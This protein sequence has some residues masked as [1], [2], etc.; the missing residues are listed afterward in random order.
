MRIPSPTS[1]LSSVS[2]TIVETIR[3]RVYVE[4]II[5]EDRERSADIEAQ[6]GGIVLA[7][8]T[9]S[10]LRDVEA[11]GSTATEACVERVPSDV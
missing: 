1:L 3:P 4:R 8:E 9:D 7:L 5:R 11:T 10:F 2:Q 6:I